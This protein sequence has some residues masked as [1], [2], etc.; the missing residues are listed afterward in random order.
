MADDIN[1]TIDSF[2]ENL[3]YKAPDNELIQAIN[4]A[5]FE[6]QELK[7]KVDRVGAENKTL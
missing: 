7:E 6:S 3:V 2:R 5:I 4:K 1:Q